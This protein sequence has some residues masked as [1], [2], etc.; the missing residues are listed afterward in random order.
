M[1]H[2]HHHHHHFFHG[3][4]YVTLLNNKIQK[5]G[6]SVGPCPWLS[7][8]FGCPSVPNAPGCPNSPDV[9]PEHDDQWNM[10]NLLLVRPQR[11][12]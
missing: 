9:K 6:R 1:S 2:H 10:M 3:P 5:E 7:A 12:R 4:G 8:V 11:D